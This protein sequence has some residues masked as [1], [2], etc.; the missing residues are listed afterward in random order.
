MEVRMSLGNER[1][2]HKYHL[3]IP[4]HDLVGYALKSHP[5]PWT[6]GISHVCWPQLPWEG[7]P[8]LIDDVVTSRSC[9]HM[10]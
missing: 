10:T 5:D 8:S 3:Q 9:A 2:T 1:M 7:A 4:P 6:H